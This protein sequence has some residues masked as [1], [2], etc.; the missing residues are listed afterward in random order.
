[1]TPVRSRCD[2][3]LDRR[4]LEESLGV[5]LRRHGREHLIGIERAKRDLRCLVCDL[6][7]VKGR[8]SVDELR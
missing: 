1:M 8:A 2:G 7:A 3:P 5:M 4:G 6:V